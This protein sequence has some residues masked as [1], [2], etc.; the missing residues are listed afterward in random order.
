MR[1]N[2]K[3]DGGV[4]KLEELKSSNA[5]VLAS[6]CAWLRENRTIL[7]WMPTKRVTHLEDLTAPL[8]G[9]VE[10]LSRRDIQILQMM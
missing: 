4:E 9:S 2:Q 5:G 7:T 10:Q 6:I 1:K 8:P 3:Y